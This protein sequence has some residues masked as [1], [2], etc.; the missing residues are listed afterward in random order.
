[1]IP[2]LHKLFVSFDQAHTL[3]PPFGLCTLRIRLPVTHRTETSVRASAHCTGFHHRDTASTNPR[4]TGSSLHPLSSR[5]RS[6]P[7]KVEFNAEGAALGSVGQIAFA[8]VVWKLMPAHSAWL[9]LPCATFSWVLVAARSL[10]SQSDVYSAPRVGTS[11]P[12]ATQDL[13]GSP[14][15]AGHRSMDGPVASG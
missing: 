14:I 7:K 8:L 4:S 11:L 13:P 5:P 10:E 9:V 1:M 6:W 12:A 2:P 15:T 3:T